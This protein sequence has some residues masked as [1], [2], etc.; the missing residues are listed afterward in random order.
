MDWLIHW[1]F[2][3]SVY[4]KNGK[5]L[6]FAKLCVC[7]LVYVRTE[8]QCDYFSGK[9]IL[10]MLN[11]VTT[12]FWRTLAQ[13]PPGRFN[14]LMLL[15]FRYTKYYI[16]S[17]EL[18]TCVLSIVYRGPGGWFLMIWEGK[19]KKLFYSFRCFSPKIHLFSFKNPLFFL[20]KRIKPQEKKN[21]SA[22]CNHI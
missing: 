21:I 16:L 12:V 6:S 13:P 4:F 15:I 18:G 11:P 8:R 17:R 20:I 10:W 9:L 1:L 14:F 19:F 5:K 7:S 22:P 3:W 2:D